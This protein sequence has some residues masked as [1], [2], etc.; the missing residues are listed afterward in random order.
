MREVGPRDFVKHYA[1]LRER[2]LRPMPAKVDPFFAVLEREV[3]KWKKV[4][5]ECV[6]GSS[7]YFHAW[8][9]VDGL[10]R[11]LYLFKQ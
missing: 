8:G 5:G 6:V 2:R 9:Q 3:W 1:S 10:I 7:D 11:A 4:A